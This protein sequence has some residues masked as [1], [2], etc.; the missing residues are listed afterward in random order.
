MQYSRSEDEDV[1][2]SQPKGQPCLPNPYAM[3]D[4]RGSRDM[5]LPDLAIK[6]KSE[7]QINNK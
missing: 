5:E 7:F 3:L 1:F 4:V 6:T 2:L